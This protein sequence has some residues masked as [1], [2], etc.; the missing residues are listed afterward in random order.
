MYSQRLS[1]YGESQALENVAAHVQEHVEGIYESTAQHFDL[2]VDK[3]KKNIVS[4]KIK[5]LSLKYKFR[6]QWN[7]IEHKNWQDNWKKYF[8]TIKVNNFFTVLPDWKKDEK[9]DS[10]FKI[11]IY[12]GMAFGTGHHESTFMILDLLPE[13]IQ[14]G[15]DVIDVGTGSGILLIASMKLG[16]S[17]GLGIEYDPLCK[18]NF[19]KNMDINNIDNKVTFQKISFLD[20]FDYSCD[21]LLANL[22]KNLIWDFF[23]TAKVLPPKIIVSGILYL[24]LEELMEKIEKL[25]LK[26]KLLKKKNEWICLLLEK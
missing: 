22:N 23:D 21:V 2:F 15:H 12:P 5:S 20:K 11:M 18:E 9:V 26:V 19:E 3:N 10:L 7:I 24:D 6:F 4:S 16:A 1:I 8:T 14:S 25:N 17:N 13:I